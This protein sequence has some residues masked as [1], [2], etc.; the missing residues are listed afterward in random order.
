MAI[1]STCCSN[2]APVPFDRAEMLAL[3][4][5]LAPD[6]GAFNAERGY[7]ARLHQGDA[8]PSIARSAPSPSSAP[9]RHEQP[10]HEHGS[11]RNCL[12][13]IVG[14][15]RSRRGDGDEGCDHCVKASVAALL[16][17]RLAA[18]HRATFLADLAVMKAS[19]ARLFDA[20]I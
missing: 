8:A 2:T 20:G 9:F 15:I 7:T 6:Y 14:S 18:P 13:R 4:E 1:S 5:S 12:Y 3:G 17:Q 11:H 16:K 10:G 19:A